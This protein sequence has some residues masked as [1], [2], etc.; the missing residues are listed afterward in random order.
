MSLQAG[1]KV[2]LHAEFR[3]RD[4][5]LFDPIEKSIKIIHPNEITIIETLTTDITKVSTGIYER[6]YTLPTGYDYIF[7]E[8]TGKD[9]DNV[10]DLKRQQIDINYV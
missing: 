10:V 7:H 9:D 8:W 2:I 1:Q 3:D 6:V 5:N 4:D